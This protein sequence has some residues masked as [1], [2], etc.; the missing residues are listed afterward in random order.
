MI[1]SIASPYP[2]QIIQYYSFHKMASQNTTN[3]HALHHT[4]S[5]T[6]L[7]FEK[8]ACTPLHEEMINVENTIEIDSY[9]VLMNHPLNPSTQ[10]II[11]TDKYQIKN[12]VV[13]SVMDDERKKYFCLKSPCQVVGY[14]IHSSTLPIPSQLGKSMLFFLIGIRTRC[15]HLCYSS[16]FP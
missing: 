1:T 13:Q 11:F 15:C 8:V 14:V 2:P 16:S 5:A 12:H 10:V 4:Y 6:N 7:L 9:L 3:C